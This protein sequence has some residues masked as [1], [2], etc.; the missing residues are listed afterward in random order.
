MS[1]L[2]ASLEV[3]ECAGPGN[4]LAPVVEHSEESPPGHSGAAP[5]LGGTPFDEQL[6][7]WWNFIGRKHDEMVT[8]RRAW[9]DGE[10]DRF[11]RVDGFRGDRLLAP[12]MPTV[13]VKPRGRRR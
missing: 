12:P 10:G 3:I 13:Q 2:E 1:N 5:L 4:D 9:N 8:A 11:G 7:M 6:V